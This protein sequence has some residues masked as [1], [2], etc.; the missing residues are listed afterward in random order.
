MKANILYFI[1]LLLLTLSVYLIIEYTNSNRMQLI[2]G[3][4]GS[5]GI[6]FNFVSFMLN[7]KNTK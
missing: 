1:S 4:I 2:A 5:I 7:K 6:A 3:S